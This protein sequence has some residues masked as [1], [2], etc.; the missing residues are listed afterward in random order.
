LRPAQELRAHHADQRHPAEQQHDAEQHP[1]ARLDEARQ[2]DQDVKR[3][4]ARPDLEEAR[5]NRS[6]QPPK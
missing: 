5:K 6:T 3:R 1:E 2:N 4:H